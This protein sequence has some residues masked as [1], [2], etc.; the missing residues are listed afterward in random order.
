MGY[1]KYLFNRT[2]IFHFLNWSDIMSKRKKDYLL[3]IIVLIIFISLIFILDLPKVSSF[4]ILGISLLFILLLEFLFGSKNK[5]K[6][7]R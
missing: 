6:K 3:F 7:A 1:S 2:V 5:D 4:I